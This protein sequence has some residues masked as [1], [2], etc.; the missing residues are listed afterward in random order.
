MPFD[1]QKR[2]ILDGESQWPTAIGPTWMASAEGF[3]T[4]QRVAR[5]YF[6]LGEM[7]FRKSLV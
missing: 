3:Q 4:G 5:K 1:L 6:S 7:F 2:A